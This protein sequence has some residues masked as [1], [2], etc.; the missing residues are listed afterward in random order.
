[1]ILLN[2][3][4]YPPLLKELTR[5]IGSTFVERRIYY[6]VGILLFIADDNNADSSH[7]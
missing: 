1:M 4:I 3:S 6:L 7:D 5:Y 2:L